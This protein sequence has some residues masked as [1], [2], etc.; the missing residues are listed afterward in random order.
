MN[1]H[2]HRTTRAVTVL[3]A[4]ATLAGCLGESS[5]LTQTDNRTNPNENP[6][7]AEFVDTAGLQCALSDPN[8]LIG[9]GQDSPSLTP[10]STPNSNIQ[11]ST[12]LNSGTC[13]NNTA[14]TMGTG[15]VDITGPAAGS[16]MMGYESPTHASLG[17][18]TRQFSRAYVIGSPCN[19]NRVVYVVNDLGMIFHAVRQGVLNKVA[20]DAQLAPFYNE[21]NIMLNATHTHAGPG[22]YAHFTAFN[23]FRLGHDEEVY[24]FIVDG[25][26]EAIRRAHANLQAN[27]E[28]GRL[29]VNNGELLNANV[30][31]SAI[32]Y[33]QNPQEERNQYLNQRGESQNVNKEMALL[34][35]RRA[36][37][38]PIGQINWFGVHP[39]TTGNTNPLISSDNKGWAALAFEKLMG[40]QYE[41]PAG[42]DTFV[43]AFAQTD[44]GDSSPNIFF[45]DKPFEERGGSTD[46]LKA[47]EINGSKQL[48]RALTLYRDANQLVRGGVNFA[49]FHVKMDEVEITDPVVLNSLR[50]PE[51][52]NSAVKKTCTAAMGVSFGAGAEDGPGPTV[53][54]ASCNGRTDP[55]RLTRD[56]A[57]LAAGKLPPE[58]LATAV[59]CN[60]NDLPFDAIPAGTSLSCQAEKPV[61]FV[62]GPPLNFSNNVLPFQLFTIGNVAVLGLPWEITTMAGRR[63]RQTV[64]EVLEPQGIDQVIISGLSNDF[65]NYLTTREE[66]SIQQYEGAS[67]Q[68]G[69]W[70]L[71]AVQQESRRL[72]L[73]LAQQ[74]QPPAGPPRTVTSNPIP[75]PPYVPFDQAPSAAFGD[76]LAQPTPTVTAGNTVTA[77][78]QSAH[79][80]NMKT[81]GLAIV[82]VERMNA[83]GEWESFTHD[84][85]PELIFRWQPFEPTP[86]LSPIPLPGF[87]SSALAEWKIPANTPAGKY[88]IKHRGVAVPAGSP[89]PFEGVSE[90]FDVTATGATCSDGRRM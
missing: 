81:R 16:V 78:F 17:L 87:V 44:E 9:E 63:I 79:P 66:Y 73:S 19:G 88:R 50:H 33:D 21:Q 70:T 72:A 60:L 28:P 5:D 35:L 53:E 46:E 42:K 80:R 84:R 24:N 7:N 68:F 10:A 61:L 64:L 30:N 4:A 55:A 45:K 51:S 2:L 75:R 43:A 1:I 77:Q 54:G 13:R 41:A 58:V 18:H 14:F 59:L 25:I 12:G 67:T 40:T 62:L 11:P 26:V 57:A 49:Q 74:N 37:G 71:A 20:A 31:R 82:E 27:P 29:L 89:E 39:T 47:V 8:L 22:G 86:Y 83:N 34:K 85:S 36:D 56:L 32:A 76:V 69:P 90:A 6:G 48:A 52:L 65:V 23:A 38:T 3:L 15:I